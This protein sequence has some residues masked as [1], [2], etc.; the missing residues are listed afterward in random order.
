MKSPG[1][2]SQEPPAQLQAALF[3]DLLRAVLFDIAYN[4]HRDVHTDV[5]S[6]RKRPPQD[7]SQTPADRPR[8]GWVANRRVDVFGQVIPPVSDD[9][10]DCLLCGRLIAAARFTTHLEKCRRGRAAGR[11]AS[12]R[13]KYSDDHDFD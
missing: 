5:H 10:V 9:M 6:E 7:P 13:L 3:E 2:N 12:K 11:A 8:G 4:A 1:P